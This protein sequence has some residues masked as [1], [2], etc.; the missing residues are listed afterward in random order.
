MGNYGGH[1]ALPI[2]TS[3]LGRNF[4]MIKDIGGQFDGGHDLP[5]RQGKREVI[6]QQTLYTGKS[7]LKDISSLHLLHVHGIRQLIEGGLSHQRGML[8]PVH[9]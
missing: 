4:K 3:L 6:L 9:H 7:P 8:T 5:I 2:E 1:N